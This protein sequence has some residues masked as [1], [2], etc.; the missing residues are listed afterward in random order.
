MYASLKSRV[1]NKA[2]P[3]PQA[4]D[5][6]RDMRRRLTALLIIVAVLAVGW[7]GGWFALASW[8]E[9]RVS[10]ALREIAER[11]VEVDCSGRDIVGFPFALKL[12]CGET[13]VAETRTR[14]QAQFAGLTG[15]ASVFAPT[16]AAIDLAS[17][18]RLESPFLASPAEFRWSEAELDVGMGLSGPRTVSFDSDDLSA[19]VPVREIPD[20]AL[21]AER[22]SGTLAPSGDG[23]T[24]ISLVFTELALSGAAMALPP[25]SGH[26]SAQLSVPPRALLSG[27]AH[28]QPPFSAR[29]IDV[30]LAAGE[31]RL[32]VGGD[33]T[34]D[35]EGLLD[36]T[37]A[38]RIAGA[39]ALP[40]LVTTLPA[41]VQKLANA[42]IGG[43]LL[44]EPTTLDG[45]PA[46]ELVLEIEKGRAKV[47]PVSVELPRLP[48]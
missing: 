29:S 20:A 6:Y 11:G 19:I 8:A 40:A 23:G 38:L 25:V 21:T 16:T 28:L 2:V 48:L 32:G 47:G 41:D 30:V 7:V 17:P 42:A 31:A 15:G 22:A 45:E 14:S 4:T 33:I 5:A 13:E 34:V 36:G 35:A 18:A 24:A 39:E 27:R 9:A 3:P 12:A 43:I 10:D 37:V 44:G 1:A 46:T 26:A